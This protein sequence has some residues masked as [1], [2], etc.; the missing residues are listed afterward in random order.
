MADC[1][2]G[3]ITQQIIGAA[4]R[5]HNALGNGFQEVTYQR[6]MELEFRAI[7]YFMHENLK[8]QFIIWISTLEHGELIS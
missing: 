7:N 4:F 6:A 3:D 8:C 5:V 1:K 2:Y